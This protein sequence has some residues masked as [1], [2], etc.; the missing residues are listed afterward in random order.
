MVLSKV[1]VCGGGG[2]RRGGGGLPPL[3][4]HPCYFAPIFTVVGRAPI[5]QPQPTTVVVSSDI[6]TTVN[7]VSASLVLPCNAAGLPPPFLRWFREDTP[8]EARFVTRYGTL[9]MNVSNTSYIEAPREGVRY[10][11]TATN[12][13]AI[14]PFIIATTRSSD[15]HVF[16]TCKLEGPGLYLLD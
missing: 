6:F 3:Y 12:I 16:Y 15:Y 5:F 10:H 4:L 1:C 11:C 2:G 9:V 7:G 13:I 14:D 8:I